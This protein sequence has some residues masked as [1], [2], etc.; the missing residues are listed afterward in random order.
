MSESPTDRVAAGGAH[1]ALLIIDVQRD[2]FRKKTPIYRSQELLANIDSLVARA[3]AA[4][5]PVVYV[6]H[7]SGKVLPYGSE[8]WELHDDL[9]PEASD[10]R[11]HKLHGNAFE[12]TPLQEE[13]A[14]R[15][16]N[17]VVVAGLVT[18]GCVKATCVGALGLGLTVVLAA[19]GHSSYSADAAERIEQWNRDLAVAG[20]DVRPAAAISF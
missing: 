20:V 3:R 19:N 10:L 13:L 17:R 16:V 9:H 6:Q 18:H 12:E 4:G 1:T 2:L 11:I 14:A 15:G 5:A 7:S 8:G